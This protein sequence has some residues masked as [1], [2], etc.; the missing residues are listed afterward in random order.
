MF[1]AHLPAGYVIARGFHRCGTMV[2][3]G[4]SAC[5]LGSLFPDIDLLWF[6]LVDGCRY[7]H[8]SYATHWPAVWLGL[9]VAAGIRWRC[10]GKNSAAALSLF[11]LGGLVHVLLDGVVGDI[12]LFAPWCDTY[13]ALATVPSKVQPWWLNFFLHWSMLVEVLICAA[14]AWLLLSRRSRG[15]HSNQ[16]VR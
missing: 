2:R 11:A 6:Y 5:L 8:H 4:M 10:T 15:K 13:Y 7:H 12:Q 1:I 9:L 14:A 16:S 3:G